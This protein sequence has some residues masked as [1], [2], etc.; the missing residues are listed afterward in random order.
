[1]TGATRC[2]VV[3]ACLDG[4]G[5]LVLR[6]EDVVELDLGDA[7]AHHVEDVRLDLPEGGPGGAQ[8][9]GARSA[10]PRKGGWVGA[11]ARAWLRGLVRR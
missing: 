7:R 5:D 11:R 3:H 10:A 9:R 4:G 6:S 1:M 2:V 8:R